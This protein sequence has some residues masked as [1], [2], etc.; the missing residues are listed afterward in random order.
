MANKEVAMIAKFK[1]VKG[2]SRDHQDCIEEKNV[3]KLVRNGQ[4][5]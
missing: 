5:G 4:T 2:S 3:K 1:H